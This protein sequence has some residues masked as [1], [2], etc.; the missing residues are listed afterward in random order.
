MMTFAT[1][2]TFWLILLFAGISLFLSWL[3]Y[4][5]NK[6]FAIARLR[7]LVLFS[8]RF[9]LLFLLLFLLLDPM[10]KKQHKETNKPVLA[11]VIDASQSMIL[12]HDSLQI[13]N[14]LPA[15]IEK[16]MP[17]LS[18]Y[19]VR[20]YS[21]SDSLHNGFS[22][23]K[24]TT[25]NISSALIDIK[26][27]I[28]QNNV[29]GILLI[30][31][32]IYNAGTNPFFI[33]NQF[34]FPIHTLATGDTSTKMDISI[35][36]VHVNKDITFSSFFPIEIAISAKDAQNVNTR[37]DVFLNDKLISQF[38]LQISSSDFSRFFSLQQQ[39]TKKGINK[40]T[41][42]VQPDP[43]EINKQNNSIILYFNIHEK[44][45]RILILADVVHP[46]IRSI[47]EALESYAQ[48][49]VD[50]FRI[51]EVS[52]VNLDQ[53]HLLVYYQHPQNAGSP[54]FFQDALRKKIPIWFIGG[55]QFNYNAI[56]SL[57]IGFSA[58]IRSNSTNDVLPAFNTNFSLFDLSDAE[59][60]FF[61]KVQPLSLP[62]GDYK[63]SAGAQALLYQKVGK[64]VTLQPLFF[65][66]KYNDLFMG[67]LLG[68]GI[69][70][71]RLKAF[72][73][74]HSFDVF[75]QFMVHI[76]QF[77]TENTD[78]SRFKVKYKPT[79][80]AFEPV[81][82]NAELYNPN[83]ELINNVPVVIDI[84]DSAN[85]TK[86]YFFE[87]E[88]NSYFLHLFP[89]PAGIYHFRARVED[90]T[91]PF[92]EEGE[93]SVSN[94]NPE[95]LSLRA[96]HTVLKSI[97][98]QTGGKFFTFEQRENWI[99]FMQKNAPPARQRT[100]V[101]YTSLIDWKMLFFVLILL[102]TIEWAWRKWEGYY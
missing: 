4:I 60:Q 27:R 34:P 73:E 61:D 96:N 25:T 47:K 30:S 12:S 5:N 35:S 92:V 70:R 68:E 88:G 41:V 38:P 52:K 71:W 28:Q 78:R 76:V 23:Y 16:L 32:G 74:Y 46:D 64:V 59:K 87:P 49:T 43:K 69:W 79:Y 53:Y 84:Y 51:H 56:S 55:S 9:I 102:A 91:Y 97:S 98:A 29:A 75:D 18:K 101:R 65:F 37:V 20:I 39:A 17:S 93:F 67:F 94:F 36:Y 66:A 8:L 2:N 48:F 42:Q 54:L 24:G 77:L 83:Y 6:S 80:S 26:N 22:G 19:D 21:F 82:M 89:F 10:I 85:Q 13:K 99:N 45:K 44:T 81:H 1:H 33:V 3:L 15:W 57:N 95:R 31:D 90:K 40:L 62:F 72:A 100:Q 7:K 86:Q 63:I 11:V 14:D 58:K 50:I